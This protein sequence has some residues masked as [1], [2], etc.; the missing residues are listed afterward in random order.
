LMN[1]FTQELEHDKYQMDI[2]IN[3]TW[4]NSPVCNFVLVVWTCPQPH[5]V[6]HAAKGL[7]FKKEY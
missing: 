7:N 6:S 1:S 3:I 5:F 4:D 2:L